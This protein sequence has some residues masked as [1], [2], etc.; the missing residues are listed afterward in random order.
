MNLNSMVYIALNDLNIFMYYLFFLKIL[1]FYRAA[2]NAGRSNQ[3]KAVCPSVRLSKALI[4]TKRKLCPD[5]YTIR[6][7]I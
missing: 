1:Y 2:L 6:K 3:E 7:I 4:V 5:F